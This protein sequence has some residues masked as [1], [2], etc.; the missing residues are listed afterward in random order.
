[1][2]VSLMLLLLFIIVIWIATE[3]RKIRLIELKDVG[4][5][6]FVEINELANE[7]VEI[8]KVNERTYVVRIIDEE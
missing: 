3:Q 6:G 4:P 7:T 1:M 8:E 2:I 5:D